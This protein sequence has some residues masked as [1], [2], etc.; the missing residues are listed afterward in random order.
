MTAAANRI[1][2][3]DDDSDLLSGLI[4]QLGDRFDIVTAESGEEALRKFQTDEPFAVVLSDVRMP[5]MGGIEFLERLKELAPETMRLVLT[6]HIE[7]Q[8]TADGNR[9][10]TPGRG[11]PSP[12]LRA[13]R[14]SERRA[15]TQSITREFRRFLDCQV[16]AKRPSSASFFAI[17][18][19][20]WSSSLRGAQRRG[21]P[22]GDRTLRRPEDRHAAFSVSRRPG[23]KTRMK[24]D[25][26]I[27]AHG[28][29][30]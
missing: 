16:G 26:A 1:L 29:T 21:S 24:G 3:V 25:A 18:G 7:Q 20:L 28:W 17:D 27:A 6:G 19:L 10:K 11:P 15:L 4:R 12:S 23:H 30:G 13:Q 8:A 5:G 22:S 2:I 9:G 14:R